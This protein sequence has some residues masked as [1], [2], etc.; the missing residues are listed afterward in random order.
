MCIFKV[1]NARLYEKYVK[2]YFLE[3][4][5]LDMMFCFES[6]SAYMRKKRRH[7]GR[8]GNTVNRHVIT[9]FATV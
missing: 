9:I 5:V 4:K 1:L 2:C 6:S 7:C 3:I 8:I